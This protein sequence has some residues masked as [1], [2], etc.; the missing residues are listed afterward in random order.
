MSDV[1][2]QLELSRDQ[3]KRLRFGFGLKVGDGLWMSAAIPS[4]T[5]RAM[6]EAGLIRPVIPS[7]M[8]WDST[9]RFFVGIQRDPKG[10]WR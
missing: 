3:L 2:E 7:G 10:A 8:R 1:I 4:E 9:L 5:T 6:A